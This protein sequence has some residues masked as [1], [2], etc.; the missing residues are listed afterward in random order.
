MQEQF[1]DMLHL[2]YLASTS[3]H[4]LQLYMLPDMVRNTGF[5]PCSATMVPK[6]GNLTVKAQPHETAHTTPQ[7]T[8]EVLLQ[9]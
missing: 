9:D 5:N 1:L 3:A 4:C 8:F 7:P 6:P 2:I